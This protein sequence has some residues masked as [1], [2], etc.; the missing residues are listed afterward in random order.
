MVSALWQLQGPCP[1]DAPELTPNL[2]WFI[3]DRRPDIHLKAQLSDALTSGVPLPLMELG[4]GS[5]S[6][7]CFPELAESSHWAEMVTAVGQGLSSNGRVW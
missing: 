7:G 5:T 1:L 6:S 3:R 4:R 2:F